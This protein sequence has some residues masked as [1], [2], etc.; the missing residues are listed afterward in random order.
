MENEFLGS[1]EEVLPKIKADSV[2]MIFADFPFSTTKAKW[3]TPVNLELF[4]QE[5]WRILKDNG[6]VIAKA[7]VPFNITLGASQLKNLKYEWIWEKTSAT[8]GLNSKKMPMKAAENLMVFYKK[9]PIYNPQM[10]SGHVRK[11]SSAKNIA[12][13]I[14]RRNEKEDYIYNKEY[15]NKVEDYDSTDRYPRSVLKFSS[16]KQRLALHPTQTP[17]ALVEYFI[18]TYTNEGDTVLDPCRGSNTVGVC[19]DKTNRKAILIERD[20][21]FYEIGL[22]RRQ[23]PLLRTKELIQKYNDK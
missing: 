1:L 6:V 23:Y 19:A 8:G 12:A 16:D 20:K 14:D 10:T 18:K 2:Q 11:V 15:A 17:E 7:Q 5:A 13:G 21:Y 9:Q 3:D 4:W 22:L